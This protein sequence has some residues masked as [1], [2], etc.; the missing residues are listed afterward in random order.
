MCIEDTRLRP[1]HP[2]IPGAVSFLLSSAE[3]I[4]AFLV[5]TFLYRPTVCYSLTN[6]LYVDWTLTDNNVKPFS[7]KT[8]ASDNSVVAI[9]VGITKLNSIP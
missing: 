5:E 2:G 8:I 7:I 1:Y 4:V 3:G 6:R 9:L